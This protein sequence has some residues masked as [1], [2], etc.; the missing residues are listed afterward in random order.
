MKF[1][2]EKDEKLFEISYDSVDDFYKRV[3]SLRK[4]FRRSQLQ[5]HNWRAYRSAYMKGIKAFHRSTR[6]KRFHR[7]LS[8]YLAY[9]YRP[10]YHFQYKK[11]EAIKALSSL[12]TH[13]AIESEYYHSLLEHVEI[14]TMLDVGVDWLADVL[15]HLSLCDDD[16]ETEEGWEGLP[17]LADVALTFADPF[18][19]IQEILQKEAD[20]VAQ[21]YSEEVFEWPKILEVNIDG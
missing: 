5:K 7:W 16:I 14:L 1:F 17:D 13:L 9:K 3:N 6:G 18:T 8:Q 21:F 11:E 12:I 2:S 20:D 19:Y 15:Q 10:G 4:S